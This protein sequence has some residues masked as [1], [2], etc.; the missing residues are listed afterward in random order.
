M[1]IGE[2][3]WWKGD[4]AFVLV[5]LALVILGLLAELF[6]RFEVEVAV[7]VVVVVAALYLS[8]FRL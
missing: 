3:E 7:F 2:R 1:P 6:G 8:R 4:V 5:I